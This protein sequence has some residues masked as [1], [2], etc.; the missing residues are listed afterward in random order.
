MHTVTFRTQYVV[1]LL[2]GNLHAVT[3]RVGSAIPNY[4]TCWKQMCKGTWNLKMWIWWCWGTSEIHVG[5]DC[6]GDAEEW[7]SLWPADVMYCLLTA[8]VWRGAANGL[9]QQ[10]CNVSCSCV[11]TVCSVLHTVNSS[12]IMLVANNRSPAQCTDSCEHVFDTGMT[13]CLET[14]V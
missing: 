7:D 12:K 4:L 8:T 1:P 5:L 2:H 6:S 11:L 10:F 14:S 9:A 3:R 13:K